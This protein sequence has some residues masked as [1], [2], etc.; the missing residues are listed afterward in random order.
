[1]LALLQEVAQVPEEKI[2][3]NALVKKTSTG[4]SNPREYQMIWRHLA[5]CDSLVERLDDGSEPLDDD[6]DLEYELEAFPTVGP[7]AST[8]AAACV[9]VLIASGISSNSSLQNGTTVEA[10]LTINIPNGQST[11]SPSESSQLSS[12]MHGTNITVPVSVQKQPLPT[13]TS[14]EGLVANGLASGNLPPRRKRKP[15]SAAED[16]ELIAAVKKCGEGNWAN[17]L[18]GDFKSERSASQL[19]Q[20]WN[21]IRKRKGNS[22]VG[23]GSQLS[24][25]QLAA[26]RAVSL[27]LNMPM[28]DKLKSTSSTAGTSSTVTLGNS[29]HPAAESSLV[30]VH[31]QQQSQQDSVP[32]ITQRSG[33]LGLASKQ[34]SVTTVT[35]RSG[36]LGHSPKARVTLKKTSAKSALSPDE[37]VKAAAVAAGARIATPSDAA[38]LLKAAQAK[39]AVHIMPGGGSVIKSSVAGNSNSLPSNVHFIRTGLVTTPL[40]TYSC[41]PPNASRSAGTQQVQGHSVKPVAPLVQINPGQTNPELNAASEVIKADTSSLAN[42]VESKNSEDVVVVQDDKAGVQA[43][44]KSENVQ[45]QTALPG[46][47]QHEHVQEG[48]NAPEK[49]VQE[50]QASTSGETLQEQIE[51]DQASVLDTAS[52]KPVQEEQSAL[53]S[54]KTNPGCLVANSKSPSSSEIA[55]KDD[56]TGY[57]GNQSTDECRITP[58]DYI[59]ACPGSGEDDDKPAVVMDICENPSV[60]GKPDVPVVMDICK[61]Q[62]VNVKQDDIESMIVDGGDAKGEVLGMET[63][64]TETGEDEKGVVQLEVTM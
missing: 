31:P 62:S 26:R 56:Q 4:I 9:K 29:V 20:R 44:G 54:S 58:D 6:S 35:Q 22:S 14:A 33:T 39:N 42:E 25:A 12:F 13:V 5:Y 2:D 19:S 55:G 40:S 49:L 23:G 7:E 59:M 64:E 11:R 21:I 50:N 17:I 53:P 38:S 18:K 3:W 51:E 46:N 15:W 47:A 28:A 52:N 61:N 45:D 57:S 60:S 24:E 34:D 27:A 10:P 48:D 37:L 36:T 41:V 63:T 8:E 1:M 32:T 43:N 30:G 16:Q